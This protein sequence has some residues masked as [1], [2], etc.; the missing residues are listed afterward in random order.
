MGKRYE[1]MG[2]I[3]C[4]TVKSIWVLSFWFFVRTKTKIQ[5]VKPLL[6]RHHPTNIEMNYCPKRSK[7]KA[8]TTQSSQK[9]YWFNFFGS[10]LEFHVSKNVATSRRT[11]QRPAGWVQCPARRWSEGRV[12]VGGSGYPLGKTEL[13]KGKGHLVQNKHVFGGVKNSSKESIW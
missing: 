13:L 10:F 3:P 7:S 5:Q 11:R 4:Y 12:P 8:W 6:Y 9:K 2:V 1:K